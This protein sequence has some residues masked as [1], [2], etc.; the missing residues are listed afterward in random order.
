MMPWSSDCRAL[1]NAMSMPVFVVRANGDI[2][3]LNRRASQLLGDRSP[4]TIKCLLT[5][6]SRSEEFLRAMRRNQAFSHLSLRLAAPMQDSYIASTRIARQGEALDFWLLELLPRQWVVGGMHQLS[7]MIQRTTALKRERAAAEKT[8]LVAQTEAS[9]DALTGIANRRAFDDWLATALADPQQEFSVMILDLDYFKA[10][11]DSHGHDL[12]DQVLQRVARLLSGTL[13]RRDDQVARIG[14]E[15][16]GVLLPGADIHASLKV[17][18][19]LV[20]TLRNHNAGCPPGDS[21]Q[22]VTLSVGVATRTPGTNI[23]GR[24]LMRQADRGLYLAKQRGRDQAV[25]AALS[26]QSDPPRADA[27]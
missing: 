22:P 13:T 19:R 16:F 8:A 5:S 11:N 12:G 18:W 27:R 1:I 24:E 15:E 2:E 25:H 17:A 9:R 3:W 14:G 6:P 4:K 10:I 20:M 21:W 7:Q 26:G 23:T